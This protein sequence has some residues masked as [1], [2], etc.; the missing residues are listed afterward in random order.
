MAQSASNEILSR[1]VNGGVVVNLGRITDADQRALDRLARQGQIAKWRG[2]WFP[3][4]GA[5]FGIGPLKTC[6]GTREYRDYVTSI[7]PK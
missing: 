3:V 7:N 6:Y 2:H 4:T 5:A 1:I